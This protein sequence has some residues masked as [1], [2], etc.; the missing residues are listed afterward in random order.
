M[1]GSPEGRRP[2]G[3]PWVRH[4]ACATQPGSEHGKDQHQRQLCQST[5]GGAA[6]GDPS[7]H[8]CHTNDI[9]QRINNEGISGRTTPAKESPDAT[10][11]VRDLT[12]LR[13]WGRPI[14]NQPT[15]QSTNQST[16]IDPRML[17]RD[18]AAYEDQPTGG[19]LAH[20]PTGPQRTA[21]PQGPAKKSGHPK[22]HFGGVLF[23][24]L[25]SA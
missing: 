20:I 23:A 21:G 17:A 18:N 25:K 10:P 24:H 11:R 4:H 14:T 7:G 6:R 5:N 1:Q 16:V 19:V 12:Q 8:D 15:N 2:R 9:N 22:V 13:S 3:R